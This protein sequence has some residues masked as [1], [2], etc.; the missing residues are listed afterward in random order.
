MLIPQ[1]DVGKNY[2][3]VAIPACGRLT[4]V[5]WSINLATQIYPLSMSYNFL[6]VKG[7]EAGD[8]RNR[9]VDFVKESK[10][11]LLWMIDDDVL[12]PEYAVQ[13][14]LYAMLNKKDVIACA[15]I[16]YTKSEIPVPLVFEHN[17]SGP[18][19][20]WKRGQ[21]FEVPGFIST[22]CMLVKTEIFDKIEAPW[23]KTTD[24]P[25]RMTEDAFFC[26]KTRE[27]GYKILAH[28]GVLCGHYD[29]RSKKVIR[30]PKELSLV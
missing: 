2:L 13:K 5:R 16:V 17:G 12:P 30:A 6:V 23:F 9:I 18:F 1:E 4:T 21:V 11:K 10:A 24:Y 27:A 15:G 19:F 3:L 29:H 20:N 28:G 22:G 7:A 14:L 26:L 25:D 8:A